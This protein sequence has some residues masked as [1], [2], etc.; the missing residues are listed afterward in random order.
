VER[1]GIADRFGT[2]GPYDELLALL[3]LA[4]SDIV[5]AAHRAVGLKRS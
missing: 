1:V 2:T 4:V 3:G 5:S